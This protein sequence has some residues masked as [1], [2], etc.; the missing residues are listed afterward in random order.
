M[1]IATSGLQ[2]QFMPGEAGSKTVECESWAFWQGGCSVF[3]SGV[4]IGGSIYRSEG[5]P[6]LMEE[7]LQVI[8]QFDRFA[9][10]LSLLTMG[11][12]S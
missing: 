4:R 12:D 1:A 11:Q 7:T 6:A 9:D 8:R 5:G 3:R 10:D 2:G